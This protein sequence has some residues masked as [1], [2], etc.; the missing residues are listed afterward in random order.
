L[1]IL[2]INSAYHE[3][4]A[5]LIKESQIVAAVEEE[6]FTRVRHGKPANLKN[7]QEIPEHSIR[8]CLDV[9]GIQLRDVD[10]LGYSFLPEKRRVH[11]VGLGEEV[12]PGCAGSSER[13][14]RFF[15][16]LQ[17]VPEVL[18]SRFNDDIRDRFIWLEHHLCHAS[19]A[20][21]LAPIEH[22][23]LLSLDGMG[24]ATCTWFGR[25]DGNRMVA[26]RE[27]FYP[28]S[29][30]LLW[31]KM[32]RFLGFGEYGQWKV[33]GLAGYGNA[34]RYYSAL[35]EF[36]DFDGK[37]NFSVDPQVLQLRV[38]RFDRLEKL[39]GPDR[40]PGAPV[41]GRHED[42]AAALQKLT[43]EVILSFA[44]YLHQETGLKHLCLSGG[45]A[46]NCVAN[47]ALVEDGP[48][49]GV[50][51]QPAA[52][53]GGTALGACYYI[54]NQLLDQPRGQ[55]LEHVFLG[56]E[57]SHSDCLAALAGKKYSKMTEQNNG[58]IST[59]VARLLAQGEIVAWHQGRM[60]FGPRALGNRSILADP[61]RADII[62]TLNGKVKHR[63]YFRPMA[64]SVLT[65]RADEWFVIDRPTP[66][67]S[68]MVTA[69]LVREERIGIV[70]AV[71][72]VDNTCRIQRVDRIT[73]PRFHELLTEFEKLTGVPMLLNTS[74]N[75]REP[76]ICTPGNAVA[77]CLK[78]G[79]RYLVL[80]NEL[81]DFGAPD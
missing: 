63:E 4:S 64:A 57:F 34:E 1:Y 71:T 11:N 7:P 67:D 14:Q 59:R 66:S 80:G 28:D 40:S 48:F 70:P 29:L 81:I 47:R 21:Y 25:G 62:Y 65:E 33:M 38:N 15:D 55:V 10:H 24:E 74:F 49:D 51:I 50:F 18:S 75:D 61:R 13:E 73:N 76:I 46:L 20:F 68:F 79:I 5:C 37:G 60:E 16:L 78:S 54:W 31:T 72:H 58:G 35:R 30:G 41:E 36:A 3:P 19:S 44:S 6:R 27:L 43:T 45:V 77:T 2:G 22:A 17:S 53:D 69:R 52:N 26:L 23:A 8:Y 9:A 32:S 39:L 12:T 56:P 42:V